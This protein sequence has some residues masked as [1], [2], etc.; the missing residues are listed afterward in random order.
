[1]QTTN[2]GSKIRRLTVSFCGSENGSRNSN[3]YLWEYGYVWV[4]FFTRTRK[5]NLTATDIIAQ[6][7]RDKPLFS[8]KDFEFCSTN[9]TWIFVSKRS[10]AFLTKNICCLKQKSEDDNDDDDDD[11]E[12]LLSF[13]TFDSFQIDY[14]SWIYGKSPTKRK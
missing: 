5:T 1:M 14:L 7:S 2:G 12:A 13:A 8:Q 6:K 10:C 11:D 3:F 9:P 4:Y